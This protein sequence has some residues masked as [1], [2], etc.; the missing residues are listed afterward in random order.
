MSMK[1][2]LHGCVEIV[3]YVKVRLG[4]VMCAVTVELFIDSGTHHFHHISWTQYMARSCTLTTPSLRMLKYV[5]FSAV[6]D[7]LYQTMTLLN[8]IEE[9]LLD[10]CRWL[11]CYVFALV[12]HVCSCILVKIIRQRSVVCCDWLLHLFFSKVH[13]MHALKIVFLYVFICC[14]ELW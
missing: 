9:N 4:L 13:P 14:V 1:D 6:R 5:T 3:E 10:L 8:F 12:F 7:A 2:M 11:L